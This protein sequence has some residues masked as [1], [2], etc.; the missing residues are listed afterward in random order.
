MRRLKIYVLL[1]AS[2]LLA[3]TLPNVLNSFSEGFVRGVEDGQKEKTIF[4]FNFKY[5]EGSSMVKEL[6]FNGTQLPIDIKSG[7][8]SIPDELLNQL[9]GTS[10][11]SIYQA[12][13]FVLCASSIPLTVGF[14]WIFTLLFKLIRSVLKTKLFDPRNITRI[15]TIGYILVTIEVIRLCYLA[16]SYYSFEKLFTITP[17]QMDYWSILDES[18]LVLAIIILSMNELLRMAINM[19]EEQEL[20]I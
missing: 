15:S 19:K 1:L 3:T 5:N 6:S 11:H 17:Y 16:L 4:F 20:T 13:I 12:Y 7:C 10:A 14:I 18:H 8:L 9:V 2:I